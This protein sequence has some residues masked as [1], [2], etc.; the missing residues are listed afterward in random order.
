MTHCDT[1]D[2][3]EIEP[4]VPLTPQDRTRTDGGRPRSRRRP[5]ERPIRTDYATAYTRD[6]E[7][8]EPLV[9]DLS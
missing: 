1:E 3:S 4:M 8:I 6:D 2:G 7:E 5:P 9:P